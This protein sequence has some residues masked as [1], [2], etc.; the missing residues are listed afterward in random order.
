MACIT[1]GYVSVAGPDSP[2][3][4]RRR[5]LSLGRSRAHWASTSKTEAMSMGSE[6]RRFLET[7]FANKPEDLYILIWTLEKKESHW[8]RSVED[9]VRFVEQFRSQNVYVGLGLS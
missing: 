9:A 3:T 4:S 6:S 7:L 2:P 1:P 5:E 8:F